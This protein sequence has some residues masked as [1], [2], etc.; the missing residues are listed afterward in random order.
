MNG[1]SA[2]FTVLL[3]AITLCSLP[4]CVVEQ[5]TRGSGR[6]LLP[7][8][9]PEPNG[10][11]TDLGI[12]FQWNPLGIVDY[13]DFSIPLVSPGG[14]LIAVRSGAAPKWPAILATSAAETPDAAW[15][16]VYEVDDEKGLRLRHELKKPWLLGRATDSR[17]FL[18]EEPLPNGERRIGRVAW[19]TGEVTWLVDEGFVDAF[20]TISE[21]G[22]LAW[23]RRSLDQPAFDLF[24]RRGDGVGTWVLPARWQRSWIDPVLSDDGRTLFVLRRGDG[25]VELGW[26]RLTDESRFKD[27]ISTHGISVR[28]TPRRVQAML[29][30]QVGAAS[31]P[32][33]SA[34]IVF[35]H[36]D[37]GRMMEWSPRNDLVRPFPDGVINAAMVDENRGVATTSE[38]LLL[39]E[40]VD[41]A[42]R[43]P[44]RLPLAREPAI[45]RQRGGP[46]DGLL[47]F[48]PAAGQ[49]EVF[50]ARLPGD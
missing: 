19:E 39:I 32:G 1:T 11:G 6:Y 34:R 24:V 9:G 33:R 46:D 44:L 29:A 31:P 37:L 17:G 12:R 15:F 43:P 35:L 30:P 26:T 22:T 38:S 42:G 4:G 41:G 10:E 21:D 50:S 40:L 25:T 27:G 36:P 28:T 3:G 20:A 5:V 47:L 16:R 8:T 48:R 13:D 45:P 2:R 14:D 49:Y 18:V 23:S 7:E